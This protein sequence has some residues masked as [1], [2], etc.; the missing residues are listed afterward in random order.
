MA[1]RILSQGARAAAA[2]T[3]T[4]AAAPVRRTFTTSPA[5]LDAAVAGM[6]PPLP[7]RRPI[8]ALRGGLFGFFLGSSL[9][10]GGI[11][12]YAIQEYKTSNELLTE[13]IYGLQDAVERLSKYVTTL[14]EK[15]EA[16]ERRKK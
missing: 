14:E 5:R 16:M 11:Y 6:A 12:Y 13:D 7:A 1:S 2:L 15:M 4:T 3:R 8:G 10:A 9:A